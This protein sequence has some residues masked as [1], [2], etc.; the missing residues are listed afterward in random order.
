MSFQ[1]DNLDEAVVATKEK[2]GHP[3]KEKTAE[4]E[5]D[6]SLL[7]SA[8]TAIQFSVWTLA[9]CF[10]HTYQPEIEKLRNWLPKN[11]EIA[12]LDD[13]IASLYLREE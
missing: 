9:L 1:R 5:P 3:Q 10:C 7:S 13:E 11:H 8:I 4:E 2:V 12:K 6:V